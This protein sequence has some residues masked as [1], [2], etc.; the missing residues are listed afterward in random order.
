MDSG[1]CNSGMLF[2][3]SLSQNDFKDLPFR[4]MSLN[5]ASDHRADTLAMLQN[6]RSIC[7]FQNTHIIIPNH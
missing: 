5:M 1:L 2:S 6:M 4:N 3:A 7:K